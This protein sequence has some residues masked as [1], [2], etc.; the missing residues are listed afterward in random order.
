M[1]TDEKDIQLEDYMP[2]WLLGAAILQEGGMLVLDG[3]YVTSDI[4]KEK[5][6]SIEIRD[7]KV[8]L[9]LERIEDGN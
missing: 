5:T 1:D 2:V 3:Q 4:L 7:G 9:T 8:F 6:I